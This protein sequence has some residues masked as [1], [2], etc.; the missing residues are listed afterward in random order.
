MQDAGVWKHGFIYQIYPR[1]FHDPN[2]EGVGDLEGSRARLEDHAKGEVY[3]RAASR[4]VF[5]FP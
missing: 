4:K 5:E 3:D 1:P 2:G